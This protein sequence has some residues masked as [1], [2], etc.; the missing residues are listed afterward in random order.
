M[1]EDIAQM[2]KEIE[3]FRKNVV[4][5]SELVEGIS[6]L[7]AEMKQREESFSAST[8]LLIKR[9]DTCILQIKEDHTSALRVLSSENSSTINT[10]QKNLLSEQSSRLAELERIKSELENMQSSY[11]EKLQLAET[12]ISEL[13]VVMEESVGK[14]K[15]DHEKTLSALNAHI[16][17]AIL[18]LH[19]KSDA[20]LQAKLSEIDKIRASLE[21]FQSHSTKKTDEQIRHFSAEGERL[22]AEMKVELDAQQKTNANKL[23]EAEQSIQEYQ[24]KAE[25]KYNDFVHRLETTNVD[26][27]FKE[28]QELKQSMTVKFGLLIGGIGITLIVSVLSF[29]LK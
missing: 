9:I 23:Q 25:Q 19:Q 28:V 29:I 21:D 13:R 18:E 27:I 22:L 2:E 16:D 20:N 11:A 10:L 5:S 1:F 24:A 6:Q 7:T 15:A 14:I 12:A 17:S 8:D 3:T 4:A 26:Q